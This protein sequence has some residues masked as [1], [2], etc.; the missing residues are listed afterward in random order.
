MKKNLLVMLL[1]MFLLLVAC[2]DAGDSA[3]TEQAAPEVETAVPAT[4]APSAPVEEAPTVPKQTAEAATGMPQSEPTDAVPDT[5]VPASMPAELTAQLDAF[6]QSQVYSE[7]GNPEGAAPGLVLLVDTPDGTY[8]KA[9]GVS[10]LEDGTL[11][12][13]DDRLEIGSNT[14]SFTIAVLM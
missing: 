11:M 10:S 14:K 12:Q 3:G 4:D 7:G 13:V 9:A 6:L 2:Q 5:A 1:I 8:L